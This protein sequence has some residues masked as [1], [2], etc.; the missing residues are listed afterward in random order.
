MTVL[1]RPGTSAS[2]VRYVLVVLLLMLAASLSTT[3]PD[4][5]APPS[6]ASAAAYHVTPVDDVLVEMAG[7]HPHHGAE[8]I[9]LLCLCALLVTGIIL[10]TRG[11]ATR[12]SPR[13]TVVAGGHRLR[14]TARVRTVSHDPVLWGVSRT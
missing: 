2:A 12:I 7:D 3:T 1:P 5:T 11:P 10:A 4:V 14:E 9:G 8:A 13:A 6:I